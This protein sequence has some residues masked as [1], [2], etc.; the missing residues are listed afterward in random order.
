MR[1]SLSLLFLLGACT[2]GEIATDLPTDDTDV[3]VD[4]DFDEDGSPASE[5]CDDTDFEVFPGA[6]EYCDGKDN[7]C[8]EIVDEDAIDADTYYGDADR[9]GFGDD[10]SSTLSCDQPPDTTDR[11]GDCND[12]DPAINPAATEVC[13]DNNVDE[14]CDNKVDDAD[15]STDRDSM[16]QWSVDADGDGYGHPENTVFAC[17]AGEGRTTDNTDCDDTDAEVN[18]ETGCAVDFDGEWKIEGTLTV[19]AKGISDRCSFSMVVKVDSTA[20]ETVQATS[21]GVCTMRSLRVEE[22]VWMR[23]SY[24]SDRTLTG[25]LYFGKNLVPYE[26]TLSPDPDTLSSEDTQTLVFAG[27]KANVTHTLKGS[28]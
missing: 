19:E 20:R 25:D 16:T 6:D 27:Y 14:D 26:A 11:G 3:V 21:W 9:D 24:A 17:D 28:K 23:G 13:D 12:S 1:I 2:D 22:E 18:P 15:D 5:D 4:I 8:D 7:D 10:N